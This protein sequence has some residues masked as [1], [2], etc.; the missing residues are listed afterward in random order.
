MNGN[1][2][3]HGSQTHGRGW[4]SSCGQ[5]AIAQ[6]AE[7]SIEKAAKSIG[8]RG[9][10]TFK[11]LAR[12]LDALGIKHGNRDPKGPIREGRSYL[13]R[14]R[15]GKNFDHWVCCI[16]QRFFDSAAGIYSYE[17]FFK[18]G[19]RVTSIMEVELK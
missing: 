9:A 13:C 4:G 14:V 15:F 8:H 2:V 3:K 11:D 6:L 7:C 12:G 19:V 10:T 1:L 16:N 17:N 18:T 5:A